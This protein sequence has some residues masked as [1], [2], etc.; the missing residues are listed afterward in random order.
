MMAS[1]LPLFQPG[2]PTISRMTPVISGVFSLGPVSPASHTAGDQ[3]IVAKV[4]GREET[5]KSALP[6]VAAVS[7]AWPA[8]TR[9]VTSGQFS[10]AENWIQAAV[11]VAPCGMAR[12]IQRMPTV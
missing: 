3:F 1:E 2:R 4:R 12:L 6:N 5:L 9:A 11:I 8:K 7:A 10:L